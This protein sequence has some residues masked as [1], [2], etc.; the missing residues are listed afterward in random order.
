V[1]RIRWGFPLVMA[2]A[3]AVWLALAVLAA[4]E[5]HA[6]QFYRC[7][8]VETPAM[9][10]RLTMGCLTTGITNEY[11]RVELGGT[12]FS[13][14]YECAKVKSGESGSW[15]GSA[16]NAGGSE[17]SRVL[18]AQGRFSVSS[19]ITILRGLY[20]V[21]CL[22]DKGEGKIIGRRMISVGRIE[23]E[24][25]RVIGG[26]KECTI[27][28]LVTKELT[29]ELGEVA[30]AEAKSKVGLYMTPKEGKEI[31][32]LEATS[33]NSASTVEGGLAGE[34]KT[35]DELTTKNEDDA[36][37]VCGKD[38]IAKIKVEGTE[39]EPKLKVGGEA[40]SFEGAESYEFEEEI[41]VV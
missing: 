35:V 9:E 2:L 12:P 25:C 22:K 10:G 3:A 20:I 40:A 36:T 21:R 1:L 39:I 27:G 41:E 32:K 11:L 8:K 38:K 24:E 18:N 33:C 13:A 31:M 28:P 16:C 6:Q 5:V 17:W 14:D 30:E 34:I 37:A 26:G 19:G 4:S 7:G 23:Y 29:G 15:N